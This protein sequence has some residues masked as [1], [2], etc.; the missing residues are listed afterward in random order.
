MKKYFAGSLAG[1]LIIAA[2]FWYFK[3]KQQENTLPVVDIKEIAQEDAET[4]PQVVDATGLVEENILPDSVNLDVPFTSQAPTGNWKEE[5]FQDGCEEASALMA[6]GWIGKT[7]LGTP[8]NIEQQIK[9]ITA[10]EKQQLGN[11]IDISS[12]DTAKLMREY[13][14]YPNIEVRNQITVV[15]IKKELAKG[16]LVLV[17]AFGQALK[18]PN[19]TAPGPITHMLVIKGYDDVKK[20]FI[21]NDSGTRRGKDY[22][23][24]QQILFD[25]I[26]TYPTS[27]QHAM[28][29]EKSQRE[30]SMIIISKNEIK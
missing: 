2:A 30:K 7:K 20:T 26:W 13:F 28:A 5:F 29:P 11:M 12:E 25:A 14:E 27:K 9:K 21:T 22:E 10:F 17:P 23:Y 1:I 3:N 18:N 24:D 15:D 4:Q 19:Y 6:M 8:V 16:N